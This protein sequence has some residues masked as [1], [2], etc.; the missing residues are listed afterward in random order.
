M[1]VIN[2]FLIILLLGSTA[3]AL[4]VPVG[5]FKYSDTQAFRTKHTHR[6]YQKSSVEKKMIE[7]YRASGYN[8]KRQNAD[9]T[10]CYKYIETN[11]NMIDFKIEKLAKLAPTFSEKIEGVEELS[12]GE[13]V[14][15]YQVTQSNL[16]NDRQ[17]SVYKAYDI[18]NSGLYI[19]LSIDNFNQVRFELVGPRV[20]T[21]VSFEKEKLN[22]RE[23]YLHGLTSYYIK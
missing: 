6:L 15:I 7:T 13:S 9:I 17:N 18:K 3:S 8:C 23:H 5:E 12:S 20:L 10:D 22:K 2:T 11:P 16:L 1:K 21:R 19:D 14:T 4:D